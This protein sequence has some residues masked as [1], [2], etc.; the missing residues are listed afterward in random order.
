MTD[1]ESILGKLHAGV[2]RTLPEPWP[3]LRGPSG[4][5]ELWQE[6]AER[7]STLGGRMATV[8][9][10]RALTGEHATIDEDAAPF[11]PEVGF[12]VAPVWEARVGVTLAEIAV[13]HSGS[14][15]LANSPGRRRMASLAPEIHVTLIP[16]DRI[17]WCLEEALE[18]IPVRTSVL[19]TGSSRTADIESVLVRGVHGPKEVWVVRTPETT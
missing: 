2:Q 18:T 12:V 4:K 3:K 17:V 16:E 9:D 11:V 19:V 1:R 8:D 7:L 14:L 13:A 10:L 6:F 5:E 15:L